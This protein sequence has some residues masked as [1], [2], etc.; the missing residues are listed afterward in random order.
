[1]WLKNQRFHP[2]RETLTEEIHARPFESIQAPMDVFMFVKFTG[3]AASACEYSH[4][5]RFCQDHALV[6]P[7]EN[8]KHY[9]ESLKGNRIKW[10]RHGEF[11]AYN[12]FIPVGVSRPFTLSVPE[13]F[14]KWIA[15]TEGEILVATH[16]SIRCESDFNDIDTV[17]ESQFS[18]ESVASSKVAKGDAQIW[19]DLRIHEEG[20]NRILI[21]S[22]HLEGWRLGRI[23]QR[24]LDVSTYRNMALLALPEAHKASAEIT[25]LEHRL[26]S[27]LDQIQGSDKHRDSKKRADK[28]IHSE[29]QTL[30]EFT[31]I[32]MHIQ[33]ITAQTKF[34]FSATDAYFELVKS[35]LVDLNE[36]PVSGYQTIG[37]FLK[38]RMWP[39]MRTCYSVN[40]RLEELADQTSKSVDL[41][42]TRL[43]LIV[44]NQNNQL[45]EAMNK[46]AQTQLRMQET[47]EG[48]SIAA[49]TYYLVGLTGYLI[50]SV[51]KLYPTLNLDAA[52][53]ISVIPVGL[54]VWLGVMKLK[55]RA[56]G[57]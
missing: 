52:I 51:H 49:I 11:T 6:M 57:T 15:S 14:S 48:L 39:A 38:R 32:S 3:E 36:V 54:L 22:S 25:R 44:E 19:T 12:I 5:V 16:L 31:D 50:K 8:S 40:K 24:V 43:N 29:S 34:R 35:R 7:K 42:Q 9:T 46:R 27:A 17:I 26:F 23:T 20:M 33:N 21:L 18:P 1:M 53:G 37:E 28:S 41:L 47:V 45:L 56:L 55:K 10:E 30:E 13:F 2:L 4:L